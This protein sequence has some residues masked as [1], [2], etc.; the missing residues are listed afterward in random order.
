MLQ[1]LECA[2][3]FFVNDEVIILAK[4]GGQRLGDYD[5]VSKEPLV[6]ANV[7]EEAS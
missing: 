7:P 5:K 1:H 4:K 2:L 3:S 6:E